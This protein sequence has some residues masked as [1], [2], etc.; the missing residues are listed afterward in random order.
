MFRNRCTTSRFSWCKISAISKSKETNSAK[1]CSRS[2]S[3]MMTRAG[4]V[5]SPTTRSSPQSTCLRK[6]L[7]AVSRLFLLPQMLLLTWSFP[8]RAA[9]KRIQSSMRAAAQAKSY[10][11]TCRRI[12]LTII[13]SLISTFLDKA[14][15]S[16]TLSL[17]KS[18]Y[19]WYQLIQAIWWRQLPWSYPLKTKSLLKSQSNST[20]ES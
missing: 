13:S 12:S 2:S 4:S 8:S 5:Q 6:R 3:V 20:T 18:I 1:D 7:R 15:R 10:S 14:P 11:C 17:S 19:R 9:V 16:G